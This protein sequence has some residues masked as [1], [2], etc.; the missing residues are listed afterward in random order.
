MFKSLATV[1]IVLVLASSSSAQLFNEYSLAVSGTSFD[2]HVDDFESFRNPGIGFAAAFYAERDFGKFFSLRPGIE[3]AVNRWELKFR[4]NETDGMGV[5]TGL[6]TEDETTSAAYF[7]SIPVVANV[8]LPY[9]ISLHAGPRLDVLLGTTNGE[10]ELRTSVIT[11]RDEESVFD[12]A[13]TLGLGWFAGVEKNLK[14]F[15]KNLYLGARINR[16]FTRLIREDGFLDVYKR[17][18]DVSVRIPVAR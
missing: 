1:G 7:L 4:V 13:E 8:K 15:G 9:G 18:V 2:L 5:P 10:I 11:I 16:D 12:E 6:S 3:F 14:F 17:R